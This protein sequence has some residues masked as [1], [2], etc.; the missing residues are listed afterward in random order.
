MATYACLLRYLKGQ[1]VSSW[2][3]ATGRETAA[4]IQK[5]T[6]S[7][8]YKNHPFY[9]LPHPHPVGSP[10]SFEGLFP[11]SL[12]LKAAMVSYTLARNLSHL[13]YI[14]AKKCIRD[15]DVK[16]LKSIARE[17][18]CY[19][20][21]WSVDAFASKK[22]AGAVAELVARQFLVL[23]ALWCIG[24]ALRSPVS[25]QRWWND[26]MQ[27]V[28]LPKKWLDSPFRPGRPGLRPFLHRMV[29]AIEQYRAGVCPP[30]QN[31]VGIKQ[32]IFRYPCINVEF[33]NARWNPWRED[34]KNWLPEEQDQSS[35]DV[36][37]R[38]SVSIN[39]CQSHPALL[40]QPKKLSLLWG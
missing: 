26:L 36:S 34:D 1:D 21:V 4:P 24:E 27:K 40:M 25:G 11:F 12:D 23:D 20:S 3:P 5:V 17:L 10:L 6:P 31:V 39:M 16:L 30:P 32:T 29:R 38:R 19:A 13:R 7:P 22:K 18:L 37:R 15:R 33:R 8:N 28:Q 35:G 9:R 2:E 14:F